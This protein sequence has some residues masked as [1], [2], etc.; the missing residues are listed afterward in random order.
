MRAS[1]DAWS[2]TDQAVV[3]RFS[4]RLGGAMRAV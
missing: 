3:D 1:A 4:Q 2:T